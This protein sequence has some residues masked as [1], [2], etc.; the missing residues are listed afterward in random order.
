[1]CLCTIESVYVNLLWMNILKGVLVTVIDEFTLCPSS[2][3]SDVKTT[4]P[5]IFLFKYHVESE[6]VNVEQKACLFAVSLNICNIL[7][8][9]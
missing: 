9:Q 3:H 4:E 7:M 2:F 1:M 8:F 6:T 5:E